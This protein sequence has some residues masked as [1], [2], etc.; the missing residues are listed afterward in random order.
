MNSSTESAVGGMM[1]VWAIGRTLIWT[2][3]P[4]AILAYL[5]QY[6]K[7]PAYKPNLPDVGL[8]SSVFG[9]WAG[10]REAIDSRVIVV[11]VNTREWYCCIAYTYKSTNARSW[12]NEPHKFSH[13]WI[14]DNV[15]GAAE[16]VR[17]TPWLL[18][19]KHIIALIEL[20]SGGTQLT[21]TD[22][23]STLTMNHDY[24]IIS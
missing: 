24:S 8:N 1:D 12:D 4:L 13:P 3:N 6:M 7:Q 22:E 18:E 21:I 14:H 10:T 19:C 23:M 5:F 15:P 9:R 2:F 11:S 20:A 17:C 16:A